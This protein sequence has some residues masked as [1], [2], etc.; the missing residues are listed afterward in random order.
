[1]FIGYLRNDFENN[2]STFI[3][4]DELFELQLLKNTYNS[5]PQYCFAAYEKEQIIGILC[6]YSFDNYIYINILKTINLNKDI[7]KRLVSLLI[8]NIEDENVYLLIEDNISEELEQLGFKKQCTFIRYIHTSEPVA[9]NFSNSIA[10]QISE[11]NYDEIATDLDKIIFEQNR[12]K[13]LL[14]DCMFE[15]S[16]KLC[17]KQSFMNSYA[18]NKKFIRISPWMIK[19]QSFLDAEK[20]LRGVLYYRGLKKIFAY[21]YGE[22]EDILQLYENYKFKK[23]KNF[24][25][26]YLKEKP[27]I[28][29]ENLYAI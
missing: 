21:A 20:L 24:S 13:Y 26:M 9:F 12:K 8:K 5:Y 10:K 11:E 27:N 18:V 19:K 6:A 2:I 23:D 4:S 1:M 15:S 14:K 7:I 25:F 29:F 3:E 22:D 16:L 28:K 17:T